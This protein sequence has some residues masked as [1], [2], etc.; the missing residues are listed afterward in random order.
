[1]SSHLDY[2]SDLMEDGEQ[3]QSTVAG[4]GI[5]QGGADAW[6]QLATTNARVLAIQLQKNELGNYQPV[7]RM[8]GSKSTVQIRRYGATVTDCAR[9]ELDGLEE[10]IVLVDIDRPDISPLVEPFVVDWGGRLGGDG[11]QRPAISV[12]PSSA[13][14][15]KK[16]VMLAAGFFGVTIFFCGCAGVLGGLLV[17][18]EGMQ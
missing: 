8:A 9:L 3:I 14:D 6:Y 4:P 1:M 5:S 15:E 7:Q 18:S 11:T 17:Y 16:L 13:I 12:P 10:P 2:F